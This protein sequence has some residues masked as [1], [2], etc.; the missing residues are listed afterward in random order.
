MN[1]N[2]SFNCLKEKIIK[3]IKKLN[4]YSNNGQTDFEWHAFTKWQETEL[5]TG[6][7]HADNAFLDFLFFWKLKHMEDNDIFIKNGRTCYWN[8]RVK[9]LDSNYSI[10]KVNPKY[11]MNLRMRKENKWQTAHHWIVLILVE[12]IWLHLTSA[13]SNCAVVTFVEVFRNFFGSDNF[14][15]IDFSWI[16]VKRLLD[17]SKW[18]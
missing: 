15:V 8:W 10:L 3:K 13:K 16:F 11:K 7:I 5:F 18:P 9:K 1:P 6:T 2:P 4:K 12:I 17:S 14:K